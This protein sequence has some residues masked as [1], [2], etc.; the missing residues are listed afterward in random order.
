MVERAA[1]HTRVEQV[2]QLDR[3]LRLVLDDEGRHDADDGQRLGR[4]PAPARPPK[5]S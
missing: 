3:L 5:G 1:T 2:G 4:A